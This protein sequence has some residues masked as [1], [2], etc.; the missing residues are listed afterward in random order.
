[1]M[2]ASV[3]LTINNTNAISTARLTM[4][5]LDRLRGLLGSDS[6]DVESPLVIDYCSAVHCFFM[7]YPI[8]V[9]YLNARD[10]VIAKEMIFPNHLG[11]FY[12]ST[13]TVIEAH[14]DIESLYPIN[15]GDHIQ[16][17]VNK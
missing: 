14:P 6:I 5:F 4:S 16:I 13:R 3:T 17:A 7:R 15:I 10:V 11:K 2:L 8:M 9:Y 12:W 1:M